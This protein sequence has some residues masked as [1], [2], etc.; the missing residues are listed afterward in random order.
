MKPRKGKNQ[1]GDE[2]LQLSPVLIDRHDFG[3]RRPIAVGESY[4]NLVRR[5]M[6][7]RE[8]DFLISGFV[9][10]RTTVRAPR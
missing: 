10:G 4:K 8:L 6:P 5:Q 1:L 3:D 2:E 9:I 7:P